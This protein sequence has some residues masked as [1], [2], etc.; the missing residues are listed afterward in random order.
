ME[1]EKGITERGNNDA[2][3]RRVL[4]ETGREKGKPKG[5]NRRR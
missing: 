3:M 1:K 2:R 5:R 4:H